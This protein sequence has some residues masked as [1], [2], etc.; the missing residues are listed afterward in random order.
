MRQTSDRPNRFDES[1]EARE[2]LNYGE[3]A[4]VTRKA[5]WEEEE[6][7]RK[8]EGGNRPGLA[9]IDV[10]ASDPSSPS[11]VLDLFFPSSRLHPSRLK[12]RRE[13]HHLDA[14]FHSRRNGDV[15]GA[16][17]ERERESGKFALSAPRRSSSGVSLPHRDVRRFRSTG[18]ERSM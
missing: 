7:E 13:R 1:C 3:L 9:V 15:R 12:S 2:T 11:S 16:E 8:R 18:S 4:F 14:P 6:E 5:R 17:G 10:G